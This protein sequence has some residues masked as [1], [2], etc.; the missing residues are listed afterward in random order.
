MASEISTPHPPRPASF[1]AKSTEGRRGFETDD[2]VYDHASDLFNDEF[3][4]CWALANVSTLL[5]NGSTLMAD[6]PHAALVSAC[7]N[8]GPGTDRWPHKLRLLQ[9][10]SIVV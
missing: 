10:H 8:L 6:D 7:R 9:R 2:V 4:N 1:V 3:L 5:V